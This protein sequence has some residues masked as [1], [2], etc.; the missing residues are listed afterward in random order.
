MKA[1]TQTVPVE[2]VHSEETSINGT[3]INHIEELHENTLLLLS[4]MGALGIIN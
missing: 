4:G 2:I 3:K 1:N